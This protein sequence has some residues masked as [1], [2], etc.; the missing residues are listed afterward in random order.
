[1]AI[2]LRHRFAAN[3]YHQMPRRASCADD[4]RVELMTYATPNRPSERRGRLRP[5]ASGERQ[6]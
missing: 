6:T 4:E 1:M 2:Q 3:E 5:P